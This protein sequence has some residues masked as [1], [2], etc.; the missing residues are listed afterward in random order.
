ML[1]KLTK[2]DLNLVSGGGGDSDNEMFLF[3]ELWGI[4]KSWDPNKPSIIW[5]RILMNLDLYKC[6]RYIAN[7][8]SWTTLTWSFKN[9]GEIDKEDIPNFDSILRVFSDRGKC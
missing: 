9:P 6:R 3:G 7:K 8:Y 5:N 2:K 4:E 1:K